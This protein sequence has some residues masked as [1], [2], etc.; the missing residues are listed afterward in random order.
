MPLLDVTIPDGA[1]DPDSERSLL[2]TLM[3]LVLEHEGA[4][5][6]RAAVQVMAWTYLH[7]PAALLV[8]GQLP[9]DP[10]CRIIVTVPEGIL[11]ARKRQQLVKAL[12]DALLDAQPTQHRKPDHVWVLINTVP[13]GSWG[14]GGRIVGLAD[15]AS[16][17][18]GDPEAGR[19]FAQTRLGSAG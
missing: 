3:D 17:A 11:S 14:A 18:L 8:G 10:R 15:I 1:L 13:E 12:T 4:D 2:R 5:P 19:R 6:T 7:R 9:D 16:T